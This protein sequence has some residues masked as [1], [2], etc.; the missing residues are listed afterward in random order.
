VQATSAEAD[1]ISALL[2]GE[3]EGFTVAGRL[4]DIPPGIE[5]Q[6]STL[7]GTIAHFLAAKPPSQLREA[8]QKAVAVCAAAAGFTKLKAILVEKQYIEAKDV[9]DELARDARLIGPHTAR[10]VASLQREVV[11]KIEQFTRLRA[12]GKLLAESGKKREALEKFE[13]AFAVIPD[14]E[15]GQKISHLKRE[16]L[17]V[18]SHEQ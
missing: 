10:V 14:P 12:E 4:P 18:S 13:A 8:I 11:E 17:A 16:V 15:I 2:E 9:L 3:F 7:N 1:E 5:K 6:I